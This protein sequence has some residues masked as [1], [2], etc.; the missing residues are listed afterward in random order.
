MN[1]FNDATIQ[2]LSEDEVAQ[3]TLSPELNRHQIEEFAYI[4]NVPIEVL[5]HGNFP[6]MIS[7]QCVI[8]SV[9]GGRSTGK[10]CSG[11]CL[12]G[13]FGL[14]DR[15]GMIFPL[16]TD[17]SCRMSVYN[18]KTLNL[19]KRL[20]DILSTGIDLIRIEGRE[21]S[22][23]WIAQVTAI[24]RRAL[25]QY[26]TTGKITISEAAAN[27]LEALDPQGSTYGHYFRGVQ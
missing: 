26:M 7:E 23:D 1:I 15:L 17:T 24:Y 4:G 5:V 14:K 2:C 10:S 3:V 20:S 21:R 13:S 27:E 22:A 9:L 8:G 11:P 19:Y 25:D 6:L 12:K 16:Y 18:C